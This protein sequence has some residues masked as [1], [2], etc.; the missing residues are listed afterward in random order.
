[1]RVWFVSL[2]QL[3]RSSLGFPIWVWNS[4]LKVLPNFLAF[5]LWHFPWWL[6]SLPFD[7]LWMRLSR[8]CVVRFVLDFCPVVWRVL[9]PIFIVVSKDSYLFRCLCVF[10]LWCIVFRLFWSCFAFRYVYFYFYGVGIFFSV[11]CVELYSL[12]FDLD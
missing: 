12:R 3:L 6:R 11:V 5:F 7:L 8:V 4:F 9:M 1:M 2:Y 10:F